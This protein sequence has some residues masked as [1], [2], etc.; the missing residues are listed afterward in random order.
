MST[1]KPYDKA[2]ELARAITESEIYQDFLN[3]MKLIEQNPTN[4]EKLISFRSKQVEINRMQ[5]M[6][7]NVSEE[8]AKEVSQEYAKLSQDADLGKFLQAEGQFIQMF[9]DIQEIIQGTIES[10]MKDLQ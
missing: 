3:A 1:Q 7:E 2:H 4:K 6:G 8:K 10:K 9:N 5:M